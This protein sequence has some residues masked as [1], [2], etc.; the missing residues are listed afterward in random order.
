M[1]LF[2]LPSLV[3]IACTPKEP[4]FDQ[5]GGTTN[6]SFEATGWFRV[7]STDRRH[8]FVTP[9]GHAYVA[10]GANHISK[11]LNSEE[12]NAF[13]EKN[14]PDFESAVAAMRQ[15]MLD[16]NLNAG[17]AY[18]AEYFTDMPYIAGLEYPERT[19]FEFDVFDNERMDRWAAS[20]RQQAAELADDKF[21]L[22]I[23]LVD[24]PIWDSRR[25]DYYR[26]LPDSTAGKQAYLDFVQARYEDTTGVQLTEAEQHEFL[27]LV[28]E[29]FYKM[30]H[31]AIKASA[32]NH[33][34]LGERFILREYP[35]PVI[36]V[37]GKYVD[38]FATQALIRSIKRPPEWQY[39]QAEGYRREHRLTGKPMIIIDWAAPFSLGEGYEHE[40]GFIKSEEEAARD[41]ADWLQA[42]FAEPY[43]I[44]VFKCQLIGTHGNDRWFPEGLMKR[45]YLQDDGTPFE[46]RTEITRQAHEKILDAVYK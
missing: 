20:F 44:G 46:Y 12:A 27:G 34:F 43:I 39:F 10:I 21:L 3:L 35:D 9:E 2:F 38:V 36:E 42:A 33:L 4:A 40:R 17:A 37:V 8:Y 24:I 23:A 22:G 29:R 16:L 13:I 30:A 1:L 5:Y 11:F 15:K 28:A 45:T 7:D 26:K 19:R 14:G 31:D 41:A 6:I 32:P 18:Q 25:V